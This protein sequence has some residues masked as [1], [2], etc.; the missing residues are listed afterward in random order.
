[1]SVTEDKFHECSYLGCKAKAS[2][3]FCRHHSVKYNICAREGCEA[4]CRKEYCRDHSP[5]YM[6]KKRAY[7]KQYHA[8]KQ[9]RIA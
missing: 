2:K 5:A 7:S 8:A 3:E 6:E 9:A 4:R 1:M